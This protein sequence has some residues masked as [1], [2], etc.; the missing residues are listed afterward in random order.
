MQRIGQNRLSA[1]FFCALAYALL[2]D[3]L[4]QAI[5]TETDI[6]LT[7][8]LSVLLYMLFTYRSQLTASIPGEST[9][10]VG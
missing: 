6:V 5:T 9:R 8:Y 10:G 2:P 1:S 4:M 7:A 3:F